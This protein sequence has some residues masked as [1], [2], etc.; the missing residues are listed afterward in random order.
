MIGLL[1]FVGAVF[2]PGWKRWV[3]VAALVLYGIGSQL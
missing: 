1:L 3:F 2:A